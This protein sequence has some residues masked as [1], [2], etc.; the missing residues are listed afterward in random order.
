TLREVLA[1]RGRLLWQE[2]VGIAAQITSALG[3]AH[4]QQ[5]PIVHR[6]L[7]P[8]NVIIVESGGVKVMDFGIAKVLQELSKT[9]THSVGT[10]QYMSPEQIDAADVDHRSDIYCLGLILYE[11]LAGRAPFHSDSPRELL[12]LQCTAAPPPLP[13]DVRAGLPRGVERVLHRMLEKAPGERPGSAQ[14]V[15]AALEPFVS[16]AD[17]GA[18]SSIA[19]PAMSAMSMP[20]MPAAG[21]A[22]SSTAMRGAGGSPS[23]A[24]PAAASVP[25]GSPSVA[26]AAVGAARLDTI[27]LLE[28]AG[29]PREVSA[30]AGL[31]IVLGLSLVTGLVTYA[32][33]THRADAR[34]A[35]S[36]PADAIGGADAGPDSGVGDGGV[37]GV[38]GPG[39][40]AGGAGGGAAI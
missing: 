15:S 26:A 11:A 1:T 9:T 6:D 5:P 22:G 37:G 28:R 30:R 32:V 20:A 13:E 14:E 35:A 4:R 2:A 24:I 25:P 3:A 10:L 7:K 40:G 8:E 38:G 16:A 12:N 17:G 36:S 34:P 21:F 39:V 19:V 31:A 27:A 33:R 18:G 23:A 29:R